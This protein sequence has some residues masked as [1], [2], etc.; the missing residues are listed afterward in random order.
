MRNVEYTYK[1]Y[2]YSEDPDYEEDNVKLMHSVFRGGQYFSHV[3]FSPY[4]YVSRELFCNWVD[5]GMPSYDDMGGNTR[6]HH[7]L[8]HYKWMDSQIDKLLIEEMT[9]ALQRAP[10]LEHA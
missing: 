4:M 9:D 8:H 6:E 3:P 2:M 5:M 7:R 10:N 1:G